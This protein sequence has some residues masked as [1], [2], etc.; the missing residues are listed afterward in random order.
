[1]RAGDLGFVPGLPG[2]PRHRPG[3]RRAAVPEVRRPAAPRGRPPG[4]QGP[5]TRG[6]PRDRRGAR[7]LRARRADLAGRPQPRRRARRGAVVRLLRLHR[8][9]HHP[10]RRGRADDLLH[11]QGPRQRRPT[12]AGD[13]RPDRRVRRDGLGPAQL[14][15]LGDRD[16]RQRQARAPGGRHRDPVQGHGH[17]EAQ[18]PA[19]RLA[20]GRRGPRGVP[21]G[22][23]GGRGRARGRSVGGAGRQAGGVRA[24]R[25]PVRRRAGRGDQGEP[26][27]AGP[28]PRAHHR[29]AAGG[30][31]PRPAG[32]LRAGPVRGRPHADLQIAAVR[33][34]PAALRGRHGRRPPAGQLAE[35][36]QRPGG[37][38]VP[39]Q[40]RAAGDR[41]LQARHPGRHG[42]ARGDRR[43]RVPRQRQQRRP[44][45]GPH[46][47][48]A[49]G[50][51]AEPLPAGGHR[52]AA[53][54]DPEP[55]RPL[56]HPGRAARRHRPGQAHPGA[57]GRVPRPLRRGDVGLPA[58]AGP[59]ESPST[60]AGWRCRPARSAAGSAAGRGSCRGRCTRPP[61]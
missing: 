35:H 20:R 57:G 53:A 37:P 2:G 27:G 9:P 48:D 40:G 39:G 28:G 61:S 14:D 10:R 50:R 21:V 25:A 1:M 16:A 5:R 46:R 23:G 47:R 8:R 22:R 7:V 44:A 34:R 42:Q 52:R 19:H 6:R 15:D 41:R 24:A 18:V 38:G 12:A 4:G 36:R 13:R 33:G 30:R 55:A 11:P 59:P 17:H 60:A 31:L 26:G 54:R 43:P 3:Q 29:P 51:T 49:A 32:P 56:R 45:A 58:L